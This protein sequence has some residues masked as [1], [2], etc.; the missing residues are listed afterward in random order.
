[1]NRFK[2]G[3]EVDKALRGAYLYAF[4]QGTTIEGDMSSERYL[5]VLWQV[6]R[7]MERAFDILNIEHKRCQ[8]AEDLV[9]EE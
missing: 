3:P 1:M 9:D 2:P 7:G 4:E 8:W 6:H 5:H